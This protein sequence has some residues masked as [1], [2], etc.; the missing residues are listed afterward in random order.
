MSIQQSTDPQ[1]QY[2]LITLA[3]P[4]E[5]KNTIKYNAGP[6]FDSS[7][8]KPIS[9][10]YVRKDLLMQAFGEHLGEIEVLIRRKRK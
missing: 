6:D 3:F 5:K 2:A 8:G 1:A 10:L 9:N 7:R 4:E